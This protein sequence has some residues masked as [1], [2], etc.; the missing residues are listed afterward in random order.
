MNIILVSNKRGQTWHLK[1]SPANWR[2]WLPAGV[3]VF[4][5]LSGVFWV[6]F[7][8]AP[9]SPVITYSAGVTSLWQREIDQQRAEIAS[10]RDSFNDNINALAYRLGELQAHVTRLNAVGQ[11]LTVMAHLDPDEFNFSADPPVGG[12]EEAATG[13]VVVIDESAQSSLDQFTSALDEFTVR[14]DERERQMRVLQDLLVATRLREQAHPSGYP[15][16]SGWIASGFGW[17][18]DPFS[19]RSA[20]H[21]GIDFAARPGADVIAVGA[22]IVSFAGDRNGYGQ[23][24]EINHGNGYVTRYA[25]N[26]RIVVR[27]GESVLKG[28]RIAL[29]GSTGR[30]TGPHVHFEVV[31]NGVVVNPASYIKA[32]N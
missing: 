1:I 29:V 17:R 8:L 19:G 4:A 26:S 10:T 6:G 27:V 5:L 9:V 25:H 7:K 24:V 23:L 11:R 2:F 18:H 14:L 30:S 15:V 16:L 12:P 28:Q 3:A 22:G 20:I 32:G 13:E 31:H 21:R